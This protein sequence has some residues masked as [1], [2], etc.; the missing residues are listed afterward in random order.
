[1]FLQAILVAD[2]NPAQG[3]FS[4]KQILHKAE[5]LTCCAGTRRP[6]ISKEKGRIETK[7]RKVKPSL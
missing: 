5:P 2:I 1:M 7:V 4:V 6:I 3:Q